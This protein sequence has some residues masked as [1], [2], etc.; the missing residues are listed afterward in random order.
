MA[1]V[2]Q[3]ESALFPDVPEADPKEPGTSDP[4]VKDFIRVIQDFQEYHST[5]LSEV[6]SLIDE[7]DGVANVDD[8]RAS[9][10][11]TNQ[12]IMHKATIKLL[13]QMELPAFKLEAAGAT[14]SEQALTQS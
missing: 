8:P 14:Q 10:K 11:R 5:H 6:E 13:K 2:P 9:N 3:G 4:V 1:D 7:R 12:S